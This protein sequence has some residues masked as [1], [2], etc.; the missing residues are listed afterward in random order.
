MAPHAHLAQR[1]GFTADDRVA[2]VHADDIGMCHAA[3]EGAFEALTQGV[4]TCGS[5]MVPCPW[6]RD[7]ANRAKDH[8]D[9]D[10]GV[11]LTL[12]A[13][14]S[15]YR[16]G[17]VAGRRAV[18]SLC[19]D[20]GFLPR[21][22]LEV[23]QRAKPKEVEIELRAQIE[24]AL[25]AGVDVTHIDT[26]MGTCFFP[27]FIE[28]YARM[29]LDYQLPI[30]AFRPDPQALERGGLGDGLKKIDEAVKMLEHAG[31]PLL[32]Y[33]DPDS[34][35]FPIG[36]GE[37]H[38]RTRLARLR[39]GVSYYICHPARG[40]EEL[41]AVT[42]ESAHQRDFERSFW[43]GDLGR[44]ALDEAGV[45]TVGMRPIRDLMRGDGA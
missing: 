22:S 33:M 25:A 7:A 9:I 43:S 10:L 1:L 6:F 20:Q 30:F 45:K 5:I 8:P 23:V 31:V 28:I 26:H 24:F 14:W 27:P 3:N 34:L 11:H 38:N 35:D 13:E 40:G 16:W 42:P 29:A 32:D 12:N 4:A 18:P 41:S 19:D 39:G 21:T 36:E 2:I 17:P 44:K 37:T 15:H